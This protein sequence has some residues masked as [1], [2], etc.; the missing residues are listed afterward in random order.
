MYNTYFNSTNAA[1]EIESFANGV[2]VGVV[3]EAADVDGVTVGNRHFPI[4]TW[5]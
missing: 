4:E 1:V 5:L 2:F 3:G